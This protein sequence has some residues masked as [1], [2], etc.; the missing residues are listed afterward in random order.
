MKGQ[1]LTASSKDSNEN[2]KSPESRLWDAACS[3]W[4]AQDA[5]KYKDLIL[6][7]VFT[8]RLCDEFDDELNRIAEKVG[9]RAKAVELVE[10]D[11]GSGARGTTAGCIRL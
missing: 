2:G 1:S 11:G 9:S 5:P 4:G 7:F 8:K 6:P 10:R 3:M